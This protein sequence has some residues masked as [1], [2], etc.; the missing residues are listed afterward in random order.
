MTTTRPDNDQSSSITERVSMR[1]RR[2]SHRL[3]I[4][5][6][7]I[8]VAVLALGIL[9]VYGLGETPGMAPAGLI[10]PPIR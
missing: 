10:A 8:A 3:L 7:V 1:Y 5:G 6:V 4:A 9:V 2:E